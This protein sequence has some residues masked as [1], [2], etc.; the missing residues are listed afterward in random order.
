MIERRGAHA[1]G[2]I[3]IRTGAKRAPE[4]RRAL[5]TEAAE[6]EGWSG[7][8]HDA[9]TPRPTRPLSVLYASSNDEYIFFRAHSSEILRSLRPRV[10]HRPRRQAARPPGRFVGSAPRLGAPPSSPASVVP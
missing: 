2:A 7:K 6:M 9:S 10:R 1:V 4:R 8:P 5:S 3:A